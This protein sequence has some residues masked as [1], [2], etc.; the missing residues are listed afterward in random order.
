MSKHTGRLTSMF[1]FATAVLSTMSLAQTE[2]T[3]NTNAS[4]AALEAAVQTE[5]AVIAALNSN[6]FALDSD[7]EAKIARVVDYLASVKDSGDTGTEVMRTKRDVMQGLGSSAKFYASERAKRLGDLQYKGGMQT[8]QDLLLA[9]AQLDDRTDK[10]IDQIVTLS[11]SLMQNQDLQRYEAARHNGY[12]DAG[13]LREVGAK[14]E[15][16]KRVVTRKFDTYI[17]EL[18]RDVESLNM[19]LKTAKTTEEKQRLQAQIDN[20]TALLQHRKRQRDQALSGT[21]QAGAALSQKSIDTVQ[22]KLDDL[23]ADIREDYRVMMRLVKERDQSRAILNRL[24]KE[25]AR[26]TSAKKQ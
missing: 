10:R 2:G 3:V 13:H 4:I 16:V 22:D 18:E 24:N 14:N 23:A 11:T 20:D 6:L 7:I 21:S 25:L 9:A 8:T 26:A 5:V 12:K 1:A 15:E 17:D 19:A